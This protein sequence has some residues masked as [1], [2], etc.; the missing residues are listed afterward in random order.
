MK[1]Y[2]YWGE[3]KTGLKTKILKWFRL[4]EIWGCLH[5]WISFKFQIN[6][7]EIKRS[8]SNFQEEILGGKIFKRKKP[9]KMIMED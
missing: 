1:E 5:S 9:A 3:L 6:L 7:V 2:F 8:I 4:S